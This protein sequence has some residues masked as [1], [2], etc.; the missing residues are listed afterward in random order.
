MKIEAEIEKLSDYVDSGVLMELLSKPLEYLTEEIS[1]IIPSLTIGEDGPSLNSIFL[2]SKNY[3]CEIRIMGENS[4][5]FDFTNKRDFFNVR[6]E[7]GNRDI[8]IDEQVVASYDTAEV[9]LTH[10]AQI[11]TILYYFGSD[12]SAWVAKVFKEFPV[13]YLLHTN[14][15]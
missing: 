7:L 5:E 14:G 13:E 15:Q 4:E 2:T 1:A 6:V 9:R 8:V 11:S 3:L 12:R 10:R